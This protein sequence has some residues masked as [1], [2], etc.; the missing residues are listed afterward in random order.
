MLNRLGHRLIQ[1][2]ILLLLV[3]VAGFALLRLLPGDFAEVLLLSQ[4]DG[5]LPDQAAVQKFAA[6]NGFHDP[7]PVQYLRWLGGV[8]TG[9]LGRSFVTGEE[10]A[11]DILLRFNRSLFLAGLS[12]CLALAIAIPLG[13]F[14]AYHAG[15]LCD[16]VL[17]M[18]GVIGLSIPNFWYALLLALL[19]AL[20]LGWL[21]SSGHGT[22]AHAVLP[23]LVI[24]TTM[25]GVLARFVRSR[26]LDEFHHPYIRTARAKGLSSSRI[27]LGHALPNILPST[28]TL[29]GLQF[30]RAFDGM[31]IIETIFAW[32]GIGSLLVDSLL[33]RDYPLIQACFLMIAGG[34]IVINLVVDYLVALADPRVEEAI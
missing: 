6:E 33:N 13:C 7:L 9:D 30:A 24:A 34:Y 18:V 10:V 1:S 20:G 15:G 11:S 23:T 3:S 32:P 21:P 2:L 5:T 31:V 16:R 26:L 25:T 12:I 27:L 22:L 29:T 28:L 4:M 17:A 14:C 8:L 19:F